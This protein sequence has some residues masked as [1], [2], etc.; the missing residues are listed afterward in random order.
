MRRARTRMR[1]NFERPCLSQVNIFTGLSPANGGNMENISPVTGD[2]QSRE[3]ER[4]PP[5]EGASQ[6]ADATASQSAE[7]PAQA[8]DEE[9]LRI[10]GVNEK[11]GAPELQL[12]PTLAQN[13]EKWMAEGLKKEHQE[14]LVAKYAR[15]GNCRLEAPALNA[16]VAS[17]LFESA[18]KRDKYLK[19]AQNIRGSAMAALGTGIYMLLSPKEDGIDEYQLLECLAD[20]GR[21]LAHAFRLDTVTRR[22]C[23]TPSLDKK[24]K[25]ILDETKPGAFLFG[26]DL[27]GKIKTAKSIEKVGLELKSQPLAPKVP[28]RNSNSGNWRGPSANSNRGGSRAGANQRGSR[29]IVKFVLKSSQSYQQRDQQ[30]ARS[31]SRNRSSYQGPQERR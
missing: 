17:S 24:V 31:Q 7:D 11:S 23:I 15:T 19:N 29:K 9:T 10:L 3:I 26:D 22:S 16:E 13:W 1:N 12:N 5:T 28:L 6:H 21:L 18:T 14:D 27:S 8:F 4:Q 25:G 2:D 20:A 30:R